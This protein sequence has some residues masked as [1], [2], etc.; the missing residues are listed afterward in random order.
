MKLSKKAIEEYKQIYK[1][2]FGINLSYNQAE[3]EAIKLLRLFKILYRP[4]KRK[5]LIKN[6]N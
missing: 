4:I 1:K 5:E 2:E 3:I 6:E